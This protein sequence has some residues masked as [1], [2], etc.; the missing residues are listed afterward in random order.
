MDGAP[1]RPSLTLL[2]EQGFRFLP[3]SPLEG[4]MPGRAEGGVAEQDGHNQTLWRQTVVV[5]AKARFRLLPFGAATGSKSEPSD[6]APRETW[7][8]WLSTLAGPSP[9]SPFST[10]RATSI[11]TRC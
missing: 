8:N 7:Q 10:T 6:R 9:T 5:L 4:E 2:M 3:I 11:S 1:F